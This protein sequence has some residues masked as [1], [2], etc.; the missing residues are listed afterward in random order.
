MIEHQTSSI[1]YSARLLPSCLLIIYSA[2]RMMRSKVQY[3]RDRV[4][5]ILHSFYSARQL[6]VC[7]LIIY[8]AQRMMRSKVQYPRDRTQ[9]ILHSFYSAR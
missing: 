6:P 8:S 9:D 4:P 1:F 3:P 7:L 2:Q 5:D